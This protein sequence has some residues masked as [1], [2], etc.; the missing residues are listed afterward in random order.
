MICNYVLG[1]A[2]FKH[3]IIG[4]QF[5]ERLRPISQSSL[6]FHPHNI[7]YSRISIIRCGRDRH[8]LELPKISLHGLRQWKNI[9]SCVYLA[10]LV[11]YSA[12]LKPR[13]DTQH[14]ENAKWRWSKSP[15]TNVH[16]STKKRTATELCASY[17]NDFDY[18]TWAKTNRN[19]EESDPNCRDSDVFSCVSSRES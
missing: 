5:N 14:T 12:Y 4:N 7:K 11:S 16:T 19:L 18:S 13:N 8:C 9:F 6:V 2:S 10:L 15:K 3:W 1:L 17:R